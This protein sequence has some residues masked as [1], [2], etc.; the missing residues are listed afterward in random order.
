MPTIAPVEISPNSEIAAEA[1]GPLMTGSPVAQKSFRR[2]IKLG[3]L[4]FVDQAV[5][6]AANF[7]T[8]VILARFRPASELGA[9]A[10][11][12]TIL[13]Y[14]RTGQE[15][16]LAAPYLVFSHD[17]AQNPKTLLGSSFFHQAI[18]AAFS[19]LIVALSAAWLSGNELLKQPH[20]VSS[21]WLL[22]IAI[23]VLLLR[24]HW[25]AILGA[26]LRF[27]TCLSL[28]LVV[29]VLQVGGVYLAARAEW[30]GPEL[31][32]AILGL[33]CL[34]PALYAFYL[35]DLPLEYSRRRFLPDWVTSWVYSRWLVL[36]RGI[37]IAGY[38][39][40]PWMVAWFLKED[41]SAVG[42]YSTCS[43]LVGLSLMFVMGVNNYFQPRTVHAFRSDGVGG[44]WSLVGQCIAVLACSLAVISCVFW[45]GGNQILGTIYGPSYDKSGPIAFLLSV[46]TLAVSVSIACGNGLAALQRP[47][48]NFLG[49]FSYF[50]F[51][52]TLAWILIPKLGLAGAAWALVGGGCAASLVAF[53][54]LA[55]LART[56]SREEFV[57][58][59]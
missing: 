41:P 25:R 35:S 42:V 7:L 16:L 15:R 11:A 49:E 57:S 3:S 9:F 46:S 58:H 45:I 2:E 4:S 39:L 38:F 31:A 34:G 5:V 59:A 20:L 47:K 50:L 37:G 56:Y 10:L 22:A 12:W 53:G 29:G 52:V 55:W 44:M 51:S 40:I 19:S 21:L 32:I 33:A 24:D 27:G 13:G 23:P 18:F 8:L 30:L 43:N 26:H 48:A 36:A 28:D 17:P 6:S 54:T 14:L 1:E